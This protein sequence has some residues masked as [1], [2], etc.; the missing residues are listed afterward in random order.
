MARAQVP[1]SPD[2]PEP[3]GRARLHQG[4][5]DVQLHPAHQAHHHLR[6]RRKCALII[7]NV[8]PTWTMLLK[9]GQ[10]RKCKQT[11]FASEGA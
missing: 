5:V 10:L 2:H 3:L 11:R 4:H 8:P 9:V 7:H 1:P 6:V